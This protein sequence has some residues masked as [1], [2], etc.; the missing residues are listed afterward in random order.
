MVEK[1]SS[2]VSGSCCRCNKPGKCRS[3]ACVKVK[4]SCCCT[5]C[6]LGHCRNASPITAVT[7]TAL[8]A[9]AIS[10]PTFA[11]AFPS[12]PPRSTEPDP[13]SPQCE[14]FLPSFKVST[15]PAFLWCALN[16]TTFNDLIT[17]RYQKVV[18][19]KT[20]YQPVRQGFFL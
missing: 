4:A 14:E 5:D 2:S 17:L 15:D 8:P 1:S 11:T 18:H 10:S 6:R 7:L 13:P 9:I 19:G 16:R 12:D 3:C 20:I